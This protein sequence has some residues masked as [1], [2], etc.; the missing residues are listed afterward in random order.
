M[1]RTGKIPLALV[2]VALGALWLAALLGGGPGSAADLQLLKAAANPSLVAAAQ[3]LTKL[4]NAFVLL[5]ATLAV[6]VLLVLRGRRRRALLLVALVGVGRLLVELQKF[7]FGRARPDP[8]GHLDAVHS[9]AFPSG[10]AANSMIF[11]L[12]IALIAV[13][14]PRRRAYAVLIALAFAFLIGLTRPALAVHWPSDVV[15]GWTFGAAWALAL[16]R[17][18]GG[19]PR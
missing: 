9:M 12:G 13:T 10:H 11:A 1:I 6:A 19:S 15:G 16:V 7:A 14:E 2:L 3:L 8:A 4:G 5:P 18:A 17:L